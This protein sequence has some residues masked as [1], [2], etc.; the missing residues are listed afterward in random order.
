[1]TT[2]L[3]TVVVTVLPAVVTAQEPA[4]SAA[5][6][7][8]TTTTEPPPVLP[9][10]EQFE[11]DNWH[12]DWI[13]WRYADDQN[14]SILR[15]YQENGLRV[16]IPPNQRRGTG[17]LWKLPDDVE[18]AWFRYRIRFDDFY[19]ITA[20]K[21]PGFAGMPNY[22]A[23]GCNPSTE[24]Y[25]GWSARMLFEP[26]GYGGREDGQIQIGY[27]TYHLDQ[28]GTCGDYMLWDGDGVSR[29]GPVVL[30]R[31]QGSY[32]HPRCS[33]TALLEGWVDNELAF[34]QDGLRFRRPTEDSLDVR[35]FWLDVYFGGSTIPNDRNLTLRIDDLAVSDTGRIGCPNRFRDDDG[36]THES[37]IEWMF[38]HEYIYG[39]DTELY[40]PDDE[41]TRAATAALLDRIL[42][43][44]GNEQRFLHR[45]RRALGGGRLEPAWRRPASSAGCGRGT[46]VSRRAGDPWPARRPAVSGLCPPRAVD[47]PLR[48]RRRQHLRGRHQLHRRDRRHPGLSQRRRPLLPRARRCSATRRPR[49]SPAPSSGGSGCRPVHRSPAPEQRAPAGGALSYTCCRSRNPAAGPLLG[50][51]IGYSSSSA[52]MTVCP[53]LAS[54]CAGSAGR[55]SSSLPDPRAGRRGT[56]RAP[57]TTVASG[58]DGW[59]DWYLV[60]ARPGGDQLADDDILLEAP[61]EVRL[62]LE[63]RLGEHPGRLLE[64]SR[65]QPRIRRQRSLGDT[66]QLGTALRRGLA[67]FD[68]MPVDVTE[69]LLVDEFGREEVASRRS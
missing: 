50:G 68:E 23:R 39:C 28:A 24:A 48:R 37:D 32:E 49:C 43:A 31:G 12:D 14:T 59:I 56:G 19:P 7:T 13:D 41:L 51:L 27:Y 64:R 20:G 46:C 2:V 26:S 52:S 40:C 4:A 15:A 11:T 38:Q 5:G 58:S 55:A 63:R 18:E 66:H 6:T 35:T 62:A 54:H 60:A 36:N 16:N 25:P 61:H 10:Y 1:M 44:P 67:L 29:P 47:R 45:R 34:S 21:L 3:L 17:P 65:R 57:M 33:R 30:R 9:Y 22:T 69:L 42:A 53:R 8:T